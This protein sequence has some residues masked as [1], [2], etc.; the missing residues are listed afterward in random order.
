MSDIVISTGREL[1]I[2][3]VSLSVVLSASET[4]IAV[5]MQCVESQ[6]SSAC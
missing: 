6:A 5:A 1:W 2:G 3:P 4:C